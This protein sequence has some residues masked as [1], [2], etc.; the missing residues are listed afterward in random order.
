MAGF[1]AIISFTFMMF[2]S[3]GALVTTVYIYNDQ[4]VEQDKIR[5]ENIES[6]RLLALEEIEIE[7]IEESSNRLVLTIN[8]IGRD[9]FVVV[10][11]GN[12]CFDVFVDSTYI[13]STL[14]DF[15]LL[16]TLKDGFVKIDPGQSGKI[17]A[18]LG[19][20]TNSSQIVYV[21]CSGK[22][23]EIDYDSINFVNNAFRS[24]TQVQDTLSVTGEDV[25]SNLIVSS[26]DIN[27]EDIGSTL[28]VDMDISHI[29][30]L[31]LAMDAVTQAT[32]DES[33]SYT[34][35]LGNSSL[36]ESNEP[37]AQRGVVVQ[38][39]D[40]DLGEKLTVEDFELA[41]TSTLAFWFKAQEDLTLTSSKIVFSRSDNDF[42]IIFNEQG[43]G[44]IGFY[45]FSSLGLV[46]FSLQTATTQ[47]DLGEWY[48]IVFVLDNSNGHRVF[49]NA[50][51]ETTSQVSV[52]LSSSAKDLEIGN[53]N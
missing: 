52:T 28:D 35:Y 6:L 10:E 25:S 15:S 1:G 3:L 26:Q 43:Q 48:H 14:V 22:R 4:V 29:E 13:S 19:S 30:N 31:N 53:L 21:S 5:K 39:L 16:S 17:Y 47:F 18:Y 11:N 7:V 20:I 33:N 45:T 12:V 2:I 36:I 37:D 42:A 8:N 46:D 49:V 27:L 44:K 51:E 34:V 23:Y 9:E 40:F 41:Q 24:R 32:V 38:G 50:Q